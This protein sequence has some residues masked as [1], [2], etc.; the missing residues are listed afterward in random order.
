MSNSAH[1]GTPRRRPAI[2]ALISLVSV[3]GIGTAAYAY[4]TTTGGGSGSAATGAVSTVEIVQTSQ[5]TDLAPG[6]GTQALSGTFN[7][8]ND[9]AVAVGAVEAEVVVTGAG[10]CSAD[11]YVITG[12]GAVTG[13][14]VPAGTGV[15][16]WSGLDI[17]FDNDPVRNQDDCQGA[18]ITIEY[19][20]T[21]GS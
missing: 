3:V 2:I 6:S 16:S 11:D 14:S 15:G 4:W 12:T 5:V 17:A 7:N 8:P 9:A 13:D 10:D 1:R 18:T 19:T 20:L 21:P